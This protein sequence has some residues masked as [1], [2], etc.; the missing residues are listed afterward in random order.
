MKS[1]FFKLLTGFFLVSAITLPS[2]AN[3]TDVTITAEVEDVISIV[4]ERTSDNQIV[5]QII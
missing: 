4:T 3:D 2:L 1:N 5:S